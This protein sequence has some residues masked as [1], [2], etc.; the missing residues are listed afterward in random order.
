MLQ[1]SRSLRLLWVGWI[2]IFPFDSYTCRHQYMQNVLMRDNLP[3]VLMRVEDVNALT[4]GCRAK[5]L[6]DHLH[7]TPVSSAQLESDH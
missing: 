6:D 7:L 3:N 2:R 4:R 1:R 5:E